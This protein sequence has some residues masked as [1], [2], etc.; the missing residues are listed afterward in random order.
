MVE[1]IDDQDFYTYSELIELIEDAYGRI[2]NAPDGLML[3]EITL[4]RIVKR[5]GKQMTNGAKD[6]PP[7]PTVTPP[8]IEKKTPLP[9]SESPLIQEIIPKEDSRK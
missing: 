4:L 2:R 5:D 8:K 9:P 1:H 3:I 6:N 7:P